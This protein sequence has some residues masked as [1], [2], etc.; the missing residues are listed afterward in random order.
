[1][2]ELSADVQAQAASGVAIRIGTPPEAIENM[3]QFR[4]R[5][6]AAGVAYTD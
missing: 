2:H 4:I 5:E 6:G 3:G 1:M